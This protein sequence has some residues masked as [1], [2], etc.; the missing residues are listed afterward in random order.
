M[1]PIT[2][3]VLDTSRGRPGIGIA[4]ALH[5]IEAGEALLIGSALT[6]DDGRATDLLKSGDL[7][8]GVYRLTFETQAYYE[9][10]G[11]P[12]FYPSVEITFQVADTTEHYHVPVLM[13]A[14]GFTTYRG[15]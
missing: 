3:H 4:V 8:E 1:S 14:H 13:S 6:N 12:T 11:E 5:R 15:S 9:R 10:V 7:E 2:T